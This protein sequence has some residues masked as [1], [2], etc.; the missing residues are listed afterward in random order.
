M[1]CLP[2]SMVASQGGAC[3]FWVGSSEYLTGTVFFMQSNHHFYAFKYHHFCWLNWLQ[4]KNTW[5]SVLPLLEVTPSLP[6]IHLSHPLNRLDEVTTEDP[7]IWCISAIYLLSLFKDW[8]RGLPQIR[9]VVDDNLELLFLLHLRPCSTLFALCGAETDL[10]PPCILGK[11]W[12]QWTPSP[13]LP[14]LYIH[15]SNILWPF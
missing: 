8:L 7:V 12:S 5:T 4:A 15:S 13:E 11:L 1:Q 9:S 10:K 6:V 14:T 2:G 3:G